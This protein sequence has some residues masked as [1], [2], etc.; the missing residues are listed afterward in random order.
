MIKR[1]LYFGT[2]VHLRVRN[3]QLEI[4]IPHAQGI[5]K[6]LCNTIPVE[7][8]GVVIIDHN[9]ITFT[10]SV[11]HKLLGNNVAFITCDETHHPVGLMLNLSGH[12]IQRERFTEQLEASEPLKKNLWQ[13]TIKAKIRNQAALLAKHG[14][15]VKPMLHWANEVTSGDALNHEARAAAYYWKVLFKDYVKEFR[16][17]RFGVYP[18]NL[19]NYGYSILRATVARGLVGSGLMP[20]LGIHHRSKYNDYCLADDVMEP[21][22]PFVDEMVLKLVAT[23]NKLTELDIEIKRELLQIPALNIII[24]GNKSPLMVGLQRTTASL[25]NCFSGETRKLLY[26]ELM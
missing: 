4:N 13:Q 19:L 23:K 10:H 12:T 18:N 16:R 22:R 8:I 5:D 1:T 2:P 9:Q 26:P 6:K 17:E 25:S 20:I 3:A 24:D 7:D 11:L 15:D 21:Y 14:V